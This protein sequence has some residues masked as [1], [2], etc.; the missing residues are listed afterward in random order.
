MEGKDAGKGERS[1]TIAM[2]NNYQDSYSLLA[3][4]DLRERAPNLE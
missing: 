2:Y 3:L 4:R 1:K